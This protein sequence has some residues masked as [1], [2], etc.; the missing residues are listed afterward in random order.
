M[1]QVELEGNGFV[2][3]R[4][5]LVGVVRAWFEVAGWL[6][7]EVSS[8]AELVQDLLAQLGAELVGQL[9]VQA[10]LQRRGQAVSG[11]AGGRVVRLPFSGAGPA[12]V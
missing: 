5:G 12:S 9:D 7:R 10:V 1:A 4:V 8:G 3:R 2:L 6:Q 11:V